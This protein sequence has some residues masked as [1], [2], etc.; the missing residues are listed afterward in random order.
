MHYK[1]ALAK[2]RFLPNSDVW[3]FGQSSFQPSLSQRE[4][5]K[6]LLHKK[7]KRL[8][9]AYHDDETHTLAKICLHKEKGSVLPKTQID[10]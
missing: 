5:G 3:S 9:D 6:R 4:D 8:E 1:D 10:K 7:E 2:K